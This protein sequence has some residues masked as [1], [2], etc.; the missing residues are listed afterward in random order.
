MKPGTSQSV[1]GTSRPRSAWL[2]FAAILFFGLI[3]GIGFLVNKP[4][5]LAVVETLDQ[6]GL[7]CLPDGD[8]L[9][10]D[11]QFL[12][13]GTRFAGKWAI[14]EAPLSDHLNL[15]FY[16]A[17]ARGDTDGSLKSAR[18]VPKNCAYVGQPNLIVCDATFFKTF[19]VSSGLKGELSSFPSEE[20]QARKAQRLLL[21]WVLG[22]EIGHVLNGDKPAHFSAQDLSD[23]GSP[24]TLDHSREL[25]AD[26]WFVQ[27]L[28]SDQT[29]EVDVE[30]L[31]LELIYAQTR[32]KIGSSHLYPGTGVPVTDQLIE[33]AQLGSHPEFIIRAT[34]MLLVSL[35]RPGAEGMKRQIEGFAKI[36]R[37][38]G[39]SS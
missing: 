5:G 31:L 22:H 21:L 23:V 16:C 27:R 8:D 9:T 13:Q 4:Q 39:R 20:A 3:L 35:D 33:Y 38:R 10:S 12:T 30:V 17:P 34:R 37:E 19:V 14:N 1:Q 29:R 25:A 18:N 6:S 11:V 36:L 15:F 7:L 26:N 2:R 32:A 28:S 24:H